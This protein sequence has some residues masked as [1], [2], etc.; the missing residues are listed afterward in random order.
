MQHGPVGM[1]VGT[2]YSHII[3]TFAEEAAI[4]GVSADL[5]TLFVCGRVILYLLALLYMF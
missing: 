5:S 2:S 4:V 3:L 1:E